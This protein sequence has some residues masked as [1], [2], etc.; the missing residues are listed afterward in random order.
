MDAAFVGTVVVNAAIVF[1]TGRAREARLFA[2]PLLLVWPLLGQRITPV[3]AALRAEPLRKRWLLSGLGIGAILAAAHRPI[4]CPFASGYRVYCALT[5]ASLCVL[6]K[7][8]PGRNLRPTAPPGA[9]AQGGWG[10]GV[11]D[12]GQNMRPG[13]KLRS[14]TQT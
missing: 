13:R 11:P 5:L 7:M 12:R 4:D 10:G 8:R 6:W 3:L 14:A 9:E 1:V 2:L